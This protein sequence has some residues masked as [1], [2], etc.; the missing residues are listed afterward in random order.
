MKKKVVLWG[1]VIVIL[2]TGG[3][4]NHLCQDRTPK[5]YGH[6]CVKVYEGPFVGVI[7]RDE[8]IVVV[9]RDLDT[10]ELSYVLITD[11]DFN[12]TLSQEPEV[13]RII[14][15]REYGKYLGI[16]T[17]YS[18][19]L[20]SEGGYAK[21]YPFW[22]AWIYVDPSTGQDSERPTDLPKFQIELPQGA[23]VV[24]KIGSGNNWIIAH[25][26]YS[27]LKEFPYEGRYN[28]WTQAGW[29]TLF[30]GEY[31]GK[32]NGTPQ[33][34]W[35]YCEWRDYEKIENGYI[36]EVSL[37]AYAIEDVINQRIPVDK[38]TAECWV[39]VFE[40]PK[41][42]QERGVHS[43]WIFLNKKCFTKEEALEIAKT[44]VPVYTE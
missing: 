44:Y 1:I 28:L 21:G 11:E 7:E 36:C 18:S 31:L 24:G 15:E 8:G 17:E 2:L 34:G 20:E 16:C 12:T 19:V 25:E 23:E 33:T 42:M 38:Q 22:V 10:E 39:L 26:D 29:I 35:N 3:V 37:D 4:I 14:R 32:E 41:G 43:N 6:D 40:D 13:E 5:E 27:V 30:P 9:V